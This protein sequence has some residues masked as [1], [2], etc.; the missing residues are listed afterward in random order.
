MSFR[1]KFFLHWPD[2]LNLHAT[3]YKR[4]TKLGGSLIDRACHRKN[5]VGGRQG[6]PIWVKQARWK[7]GINREGEEKAASSDLRWTGCQS[8]TQIW[9]FFWVAHKAPQILSQVSH[10]F[11]VSYTDSLFKETLIKKKKIQLAKGKIKL[12]PNSKFTCRSTQRISLWELA[13]YRDISH[14]YLSSFW[15]LFS[16]SN[17]LKFWFF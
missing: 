16:A 13:M 5:I 14:T 8:W 6:C 2:R 9:H 1:E 7:G 4:S 12:V 3:D 17:I 15:K 11:T 10:G